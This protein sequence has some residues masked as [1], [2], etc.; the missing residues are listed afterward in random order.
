[1]YH[2]LRKLAVIAG[3]IFMF[4]LALN[5][6]AGQIAPSQ[7]NPDPGFAQPHSNAFGK[8]LDEWM[9]IYL[10]WL[11]DGADPDA[12]VRNVGF[13]P[14]IGTSPFEVEVESGTALVLPV[15]TRV[16][17]PLLPDEWFGDPDHIFGEVQLDD[18]PILEVNE[19]YY[20]GP[21]YFDPPLDWPSA[22]RKIYFY[23]ALVC[24]IKPLPPGEHKIV[25]HAE[26]KD[27]SRVYNNTWIINVIPGRVEE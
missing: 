26:F 1:M 11:A 8:S 19:N 3:V 22:G 21:T 7:R 10:E 25:L 20:V 12:R 27:A 23:Q 16:T 15:A 14:I 18:K 17:Y 9:G 5:V 24:V 2:S 6:Q 4:L 13:L